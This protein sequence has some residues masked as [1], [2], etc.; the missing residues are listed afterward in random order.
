MQKEKGVWER[1]C[2]VNT[3][4]DKGTNASYLGAGVR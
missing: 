4:Q 1:W 3:P 2:F